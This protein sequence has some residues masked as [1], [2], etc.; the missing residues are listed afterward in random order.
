MNPTQVKVV[1]QVDKQA[2]VDLA[3]E[4]IK[5]PSF[6]LEET[7]VATFLAGFFGDRGYE[8]DLQE[9]EPGRFQTIATLKGTG[10]GRSLMLNGHTDINSLT[11]RW[12]RDPWIPV[13]EGDRLYGHG[14][15]NMKGGLASIIMA[16]E[17]VRTSGFRLKGDLV[18]ACVV[19]ETQGGEGTNFLMASGLRTDMAVVAEPFGAGN[20][21]T[22]HSGIVHMAIHTYGVTGHIRQLEGTVNAVVK[23]TRIINSV[24]GVEFTYQSREDLPDLP[25]LNVGSVIG[26]LGQDYVLVEPPYIPDICTIIVDV[27]FLP[28]QT[29]DGIV[30]D[31][32]RALDP[33]TVEDP[34]LSYE[35]EI[36]PPDFFK[37]RRSLVMDPL[38]VPP[39]AEIVQAVAR[40]YQDLTGR[41]PKAIGAV[42]PYSYTAND[43]CHLWKA[44]IPCLLYGPAVVRGGDGEDDSCVMISE[45]VE[46]TKVLA[47]TALDVCDV[48]SL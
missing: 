13:V 48:E 43:T 11:R 23:M 46:C 5:I 34:E 7:P 33:L 1:D 40:S 22:V 39:D 31:V 20:L 37:G 10:G 19:G 36:P 18:V 26:G 25:K 27:H 32:R 41:R 28:G 16:A 4:L 9:V 8:V 38:D 47:L 44:G 24:Q 45:M 2:V 12:R 29:V 35:I 42:L 3:G 14:V 21:V 6:K 15:Q 30:A 17:A